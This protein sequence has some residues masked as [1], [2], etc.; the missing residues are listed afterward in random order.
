LIYASMDAG[1]VYDLI[2]LE[3]DTGDH[4]EN[5]Q[6]LVAAMSYL[7]ETGIEEKRTCRPFER[8]KKYTI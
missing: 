3:H 4:M 2:Y 8:I 1:L 5:Y 7:K 6:R